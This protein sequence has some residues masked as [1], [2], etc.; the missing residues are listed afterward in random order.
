MK[1]KK[2]WFNNWDDSTVL[3]PARLHFSCH[4]E[5]FPRIKSLGIQQMA[6]HSAGKLLAKIITSSLLD[7][8]E[9]GCPWFF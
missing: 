5:K 6:I 4:V 3:Q 9:P 2:L 8:A 7:T 1:D